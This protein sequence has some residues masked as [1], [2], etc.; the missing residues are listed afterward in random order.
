M[1]GGFLARIEGAFESRLLDESIARGPVALGPATLVI[2][3]GSNELA[4]QH[5]QR[6]DV[7][8]EVGEDIARRMAAFGITPLDNR[9]ESSASRK[10][11]ELTGLLHTLAPLATAVILPK[12]NQL[13][14]PIGEH[15][16]VAAEYLEGGSYH[17]PLWAYLKVRDDE[18]IETLASTGMWTFGLP[19]VAMP[20]PANVDRKDV[21]LALGALQREMVAEGIWFNDGAEFPSALGPLRIWGARDALFAVPAAWEVT[22]PIMAAYDRFVRLRA[23]GLLLGDHTHHHI[24]ASEGEVAMEHFLRSGGRSL[25]LTNGLSSYAQRGSQPEDENVHVELA[26]NSPDLGP[27][28]NQWL[29]WAIGCLLGHDGS[30]PILPRDR[31]VLPEPANGIAGAIVWPFGHVTP[32]TPEE[33]IVQLWDLIPFTPEELASFRSDPHAQRRWMDERIE[34]NDMPE[35]HRRWAPRASPN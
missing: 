34:R 12:A 20:R 5:H 22:R 35:I 16:P 19:D 14:L 17:F 9:I 4:R 28:A 7:E 33:P 25:A 6:S 13:A 24:P 3:G 11:R 32:R 31:L 27:W 1:P 29:S 8:R 2:S 21:T 15:T 30:R 26:I 18:S 10:M 23:Y